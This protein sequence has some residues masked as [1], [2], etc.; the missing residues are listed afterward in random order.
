MFLP[1]SNFKLF[2]RQFA[3]VAI[4][5]EEISRFEALFL[6]SPVVILELVKTAHVPQHAF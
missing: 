6:D 4:K 2:I 1:Y 5:D 3:S